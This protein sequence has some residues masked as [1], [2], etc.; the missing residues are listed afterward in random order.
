MPNKK[1]KRFMLRKK[2]TQKTTTQMVKIYKAIIKAMRLWKR[3]ILEE[4]E[5]ET[6]RSHPGLGSLLRLFLFVC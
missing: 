2:N 6:S 5:E 4:I 3:C 1:K